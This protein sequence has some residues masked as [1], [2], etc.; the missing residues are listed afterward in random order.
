MGR[1]L[2][3]T[4]FLH[5]WA[6]PMGLANTGLHLVVENAERKVRIREKVRLEMVHLGPG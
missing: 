3:A 1:D 2:W 6:S 4:A 5:Q